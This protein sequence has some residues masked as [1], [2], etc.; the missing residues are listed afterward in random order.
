[1]RTP[2]R[3]YV[4]SHR[5]S[6]SWAEIDHD[7]GELAVHTKSGDG[8]S[9]IAVGRPW[10]FPALSLPA[11]QGHGCEVQKRSAQLTPSKVHVE[12]IK[13]IPPASWIRSLVFTRLRRRSDRTLRG[14]SLGLCG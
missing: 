12:I 14:V 2:D 10:T 1:M 5:F 7:A 8:P 13:A 4:F 6:S 9:F 3:R 11:A